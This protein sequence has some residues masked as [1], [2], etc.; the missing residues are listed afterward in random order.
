MNIKS[1]DIQNLAKAELYKALQG[2]EVISEEVVTKKLDENDVLKETTIKQT[3]KFVKIDAKDA[4]KILS[5]LDPDFKPKYTKSNDDSEDL[6]DE[7]NKYY[8]KGD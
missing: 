4:V 1:Q 8:A 3:K 2:Y 6:D 7:L 5:A